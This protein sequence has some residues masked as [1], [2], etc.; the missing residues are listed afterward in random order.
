MQMKGNLTLKTAKPKTNT[1]LMLD[2]FWT[3]LQNPNL[4][5][6]ISDAYQID[7]YAT[8]LSFLGKTT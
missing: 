3:N 1:G 8:F 4:V 7:H 5:F 2:H 6:N